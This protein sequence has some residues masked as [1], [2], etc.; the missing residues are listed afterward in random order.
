MKSRLTT[1][2]TN[3]ATLVE[4]MDG[5][6]LPPDFPDGIVIFSANYG[7]ELT[8]YIDNA[9]NIAGRE[10][11]LAIFGDLFGRDGWI[12][13]RDYGNTYFNWK[14]SFRDVAITLNHAEDIP[15]PI[16]KTPV[17]P[18][19]FPILLGNVQESGQYEKPSGDEDDA[20]L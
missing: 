3:V 15:L 11:L 13:H 19:A 2:Q 1:L 5:I 14:K 12:K 20:I 17:A 7:P 18:T 8:I 16:D 9:P 10:Q 6:V 4:A